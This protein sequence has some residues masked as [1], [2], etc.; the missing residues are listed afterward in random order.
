[1]ERAIKAKGV[2]HFKVKKVKAHQTKESKANETVKEAKAREIN[3]AADKLAV[4]GA[5][6]HQIKDEVLKDRADFI[7]MC[8]DGQDQ[9]VAQAARSG[10][11]GR[12]DHV[13]AEFLFGSWQ[14]DPGLASTGERVIN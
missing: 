10:R 14:G 11:D 2:E 3:E 9:Q 12:N 13:T 6:H 4:G 5:A 1:M 8:Q 7:K